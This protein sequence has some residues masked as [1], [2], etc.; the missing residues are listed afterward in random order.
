MLFAE[1]PKLST[2]NDQIRGEGA[3]ERNAQVADMTLMNAMSKFSPKLTFFTHSGESR[4]RM[5]IFLSHFLQR[6]QS[7]MLFPIRLE[8]AAL[9]AE[10]RLLESSVGSAEPNC[11]LRESTKGQ[12]QYC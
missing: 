8:L 1:A 10:A 11:I 4:A 12:N 6:R 2:V 5:L 9:V 7:W 3:G